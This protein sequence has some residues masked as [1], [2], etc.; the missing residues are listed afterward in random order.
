MRLA[1]ESNKGREIL[2]RTRVFCNYRRRDIDLAVDR[3]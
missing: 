3:R 2:R 1:T